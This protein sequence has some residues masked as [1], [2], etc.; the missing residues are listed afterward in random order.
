M[1]QNSENITKVITYENT[2][3]NMF[4]LDETHLGAV[5]GLILPRD[6]HPAH[7]QVELVGESAVR[8]VSFVVLLW[9]PKT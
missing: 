6:F 8:L 4:P 3:K 9:P 2:Y 7:Q 1:L 5:R